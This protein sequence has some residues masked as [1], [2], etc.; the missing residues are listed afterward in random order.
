MAIFTVRA[1]V[2]PSERSASRKTKGEVFAHASETVKQETW[3]SAVIVSD[4]I[5]TLR[6]EVAAHSDFEVWKRSGKLAN[7]E[8]KQ[9]WNDHRANAPYEDLPERLA[10]SA[11]LTTRSIY[12]SWFALRESLQIRVDWLKR[13]LDIAKSDVELLQVCGCELE[14]MKAKAHEILEVVKAEFEA[15]QSKQTVN[16]VGQKVFVNA[17]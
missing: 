1:R 17:G 2:I 7:K 9:L 6:V 8:L 15:D 14:Q 13:W 12:D 11:W 3:E 4:L 10:R 16:A 5:E